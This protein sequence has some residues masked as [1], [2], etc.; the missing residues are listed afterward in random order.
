MSHQRKV[1]VVG[2]NVEVRRL[3]TQH[4]GGVGAEAWPFASGSDFLGI[5]E[6]LAPACILL[7]MDE[8]D[9]PGIEILSEIVAREIAWPV[10]AISGREELQLA[11]E[12]MKLGALDF[13][14]MPLSREV[15]AL[16][17]APAWKALERVVE[18]S[19]SRRA[20][21][22]RLARL[23]AREMDVLLAL[24]SGRFNKAIAHDFGISVRTIEMHRAHIMAKL[25]VRS[26][27]EAALL[28]P[29]AG[30]DVPV[31]A[32]AAAKARAATDS[33]PTYAGSACRDQL[34]ALARR[35]SS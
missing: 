25:E 31:A 5:L 23:T 13:L 30:L 15:L 18:A 17:L 22:E 28:A 34:T 6:H 32:A 12:A 33:A 4:I 9:V 2:R 26:L 1:Y 19:E 10:I 21:Q 3:L 20:A 35:L 7:D 29:Q 24:L 8:G 16:A 11:I 14:R 27:A